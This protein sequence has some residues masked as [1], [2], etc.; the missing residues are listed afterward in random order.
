M[1]ILQSLGFQDII[2]SSVIIISS[3]GNQWNG[4]GY[5]YRM[6]VIKIPNIYLDLKI[7]KQASNIF[8]NLELSKELG[9]IY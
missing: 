6:L 9:S 3:K 7:N 5:G 4:R 8:C 1:V 2:S